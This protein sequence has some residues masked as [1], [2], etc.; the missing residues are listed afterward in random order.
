MSLSKEELMK[1][2]KMEKP[3]IVILGA[4]ASRAAFPHGDKNGKSLPIMNDLIDILELRDLLKSSG[5]D[6]KQSNFEDIYDHLCQNDNYSDLKEKLEH[7]VYCYFDRL[8]IPDKPT[9]YDHLL[10]SLREKDVIATFNW[11]SLLFQAYSRNK[12]RFKLPTV[13][14]L[15]GNVAVGF[16]KKDKLV[17]FNGNLCPKCKKKFTPTTLLYPIREKNYDKDGFISLQWKCLQ[18]AIKVGF[19][20]T[21]F[22]YGAPKSDTRAI[23]LMKSAW[24]EIRNRKMEQTEIIDIKTED[25][26]YSTWKEFIYSHHFEVHDNFYDSWIAQFPRRTGEAYY[27]QYILAKFLD[28]NPIPRDL[29][30]EKLWEWLKPFQDIE[31]YK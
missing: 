2:I 14:C 27:D 21:F 11:D 18:N 23:Q 6:L 17:G 3:H 26:L 7:R 15:H 4:G 29:S 19:M 16:C 10:L 31:Q 30:L 5:V 24:G 8:R 20:I 22:G 25:E 28:P 12:Q 9:I 1:Q 13:L